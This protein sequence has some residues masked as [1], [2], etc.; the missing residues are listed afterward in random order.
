MESLVKEKKLHLR[1]RRRVRPALIQPPAVMLQRNRWEMTW[2]ETES[3][4][5]LGKLWGWLWT[6]WT[7]RRQE[8]Q[9]GSLPHSHTR[10]QSPASLCPSCHGRKW[11]ACSSE[12]MS[13][14]GLQNIQNCFTK[15]SHMGS[16]GDTTLETG[17]SFKGRSSSRRQKAER[18]SSTCSVATAPAATV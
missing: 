12:S 10:K 6:L 4:P 18:G 11:P 13:A 3:A 8:S 9:E 16:S 14:P 5:K 7:L 1:G 15:H 2:A 17:C